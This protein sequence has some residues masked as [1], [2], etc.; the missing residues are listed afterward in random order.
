MV[1]VNSDFILCVKEMLV[2]Q[3][4]KLIK[5]NDAAAKKIGFRNRK[6]CLCLVLS[7]QHSDFFPIH[8]PMATLPNISIP[9]FEKG[10]T[11]TNPYIAYSTILSKILIIFTKAFKLLTFLL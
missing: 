10:I 2:R 1:F 9:A 5:R 6:R 4:K 3:D 7:N 11:K 8:A